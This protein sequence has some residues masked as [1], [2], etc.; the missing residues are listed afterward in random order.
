MQI[1]ISRILIIAEDK[2][3]VDAL[4]EFFESHAYE[5]EIALNEKIA[6]NIINERK[7]DV[8]LVG[9][10]DE[11]ALNLEIIENIRASNSIIPII[12]MGGEK[13]KRTE[14]KIIK[15]GAQVFVPD[16]VENEVLLNE[17]K[18]ISSRD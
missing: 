1:I 3:V 9:F 6:I 5:A 17:V 11:N 18:R 2:Q 7:M 15:A 13:S 8:V 12:V 4:L 16:P 14:N 10:K